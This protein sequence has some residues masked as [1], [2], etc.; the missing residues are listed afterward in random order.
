MPAQP[1]ARSKYW[2]SM[3]T[4]STARASTRPA[5]PAAA[6]CSSAAT[7]MAQGPSRT[8]LLLLYLLIALSVQMPLIRAP[9]AGLLFGRTALR[10]SAALLLPVAENSQVMAA[11]WRPLD[12][13]YE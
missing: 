9:A 6:Q 7:S 10:R 1:A 3:W 12:N 11:W 2:D 13:T 8:L 5:M 4:S